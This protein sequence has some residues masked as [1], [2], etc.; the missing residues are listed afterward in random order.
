MGKSLSRVP[1]KPFCCIAFFEVGESGERTVGRV[2]RGGPRY[3]SWVLRAI[4]S[5][6]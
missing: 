4:G 5:S 6:F 3:R 2:G 1:T